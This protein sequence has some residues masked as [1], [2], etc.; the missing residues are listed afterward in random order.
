MTAS[1]PAY[2]SVAS[3]SRSWAEHFA[4]A[5]RSLAK[6][7]AFA[8]PSAL[9]IALGIGTATAVF[10]LVYA[11]LLRPFPYPNADRMVRVF[12][13]AEKEQGA[14]RNCSLLDIEE[15]NRRSAHG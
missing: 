10:S 8:V 5:W 1:R 9:T 6:A 2:Q 4:C 12:T 3:S 15:Y 14:E 13:V 11:V 7:P